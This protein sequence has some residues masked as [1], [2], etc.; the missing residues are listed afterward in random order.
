VIAAVIE[1]GDIHARV[2]LYR[3]FTAPPR[4]Q[5][6]SA[7]HRNRPPQEC[8]FFANADHVR[9]I[10]RDLGAVRDVLGRAGE[11]RNVAV[12]PDRSGRRRRDRRAGA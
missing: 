4:G 2:R 11:P 10:A 8:L 1:L 6:A 12:L 5:P 3:I 9:N 7:G